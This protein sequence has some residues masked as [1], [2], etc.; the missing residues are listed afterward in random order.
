MREC[1]GKLILQMRPQLRHELRTGIYTLGLASVVAG[2]LD[3]VWSGFDPA[4][5]PVQAWGDNIPGVAA[6]AWIAG[7]LLIAGG[8]AILWQKTARAG[9]VILAAPYLLFTLFWLPR[10]STAPR[11]L[12]Y[13]PSVYLGVFGGPCGQLIVVAAAMLVYTNAAPP[14]AAPRLHTA[15]LIARWMFGISALVFGIN[16]LTG[17]REIASEVPAWI[18]PGGAFWA[19][20]TGIA[21][22]AAGLALLSGILDTLAARV[23]ALMLFLFSAFYLVPAIFAHPHSHATWGGNAYNLAAAGSALLLAGSLA[24]EREMDRV[25]WPKERWAGTT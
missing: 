7:L 13:R 12:G 24:L 16:H 2:I 23:L 5:Q 21:F 9:A 6:L 15:A 8:L 20:F 1:I 11:V 4:H 3:V 18:P 17:V 22:I 19:V 25:N 10:F 14:S